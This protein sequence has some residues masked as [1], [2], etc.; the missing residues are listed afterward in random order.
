MRRASALLA[1]VSACTPARAPIEVVASPVAAPS[2]TAAP[3]VEAS[4][5]VTFA[6]LSPVRP[7]VELPALVELATSES[8]ASARVTVRDGGRA[9]VVARVALLLDGG[10]ARVFGSLPIAVAL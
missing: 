1:L 10:P 8:A 5:A 7:E 4:G 3:S 9:G 6:Q 2:A